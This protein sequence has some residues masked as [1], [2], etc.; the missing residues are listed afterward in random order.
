MLGKVDTGQLRGPENSEGRRDSSK[1]LEEE[2][3]FFLI[4][5]WY[6]PAGIVFPTST[7]IR[8]HPWR[9]KQERGFPH[10]ARVSYLDSE[11]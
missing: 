5:S 11:R 9:V 7:S 3:P 6:R 1:Y 10:G 2:K 4:E 8:S